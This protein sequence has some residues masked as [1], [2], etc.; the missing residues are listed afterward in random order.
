MKKEAQDSRR[1]EIERA[2]YAVLAEKG[3]AGTSMLAVAK[4]AKASNETLYRW[5]GDKTGL[6]AA[7][8]ARNAETAK[9][10]LQV[11]LRDDDNPV[12]TLRRLAPILLGA[13]TSERVVALNRAAAADDSGTLGQAIAAGGRDTVAPMIGAVIEQ[14]ILKGQIAAPSARIA[15]EWYIALVIGDAQ[16]RRVIGAVPEPS[17][18]HIATLADTRVAAF[19]KLVAVS[20]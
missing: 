9:M 7:L 12:T 6:F 10:S 15:T 8:V 3:Y 18:A 20:P 17:Q 19:L 11:A 1:A 16:I 5:Y 14:A 4:S 13:L 2:A